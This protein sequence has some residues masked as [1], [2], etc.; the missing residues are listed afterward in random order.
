MDDTVVVDR[1]NG[2]RKTGEQQQAWEQP[3]YGDLEEVGPKGVEEEVEVLSRLLGGRTELWSHRVL[4]LRR[5]ARLVSSPWVDGLQGTEGVVDK[6][7]E[8][9][10]VQTQ[11]LRSAVVKEACVTVE[12]MVERIILSQSAV[13][14]LFDAVFGLVIK[15]VKVMA[16]AGSNA[17]KAVAKR[18]CP[19]TTLSILCDKMKTASHPAQ[20]EMAMTFLGATLSASGLS[21]LD[22]ESLRSCLEV[23]LSD[24]SGPVR[25]AAKHCWVRILE[26]NEDEAFKLRGALP[27]QLVLRLENSSVGKENV[28]S[29]QPA[30]KASRKPP[31]GKSENLD[32]DQVPGKVL[33]ESQRGP[34]RAAH[35]Q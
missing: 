33:V 9:V 35:H 18:S 10:V 31:F 1:E 12:V 13:E 2:G 27:P 15:T 21:S 32:E 24:P 29:R 20:R 22:M 14:K 28:I 8:L 34:L 4:G 7:V 5:V 25:G 6:V 26:A 23:G 17:G 3:G 11:D 30:F 19:E 16:V